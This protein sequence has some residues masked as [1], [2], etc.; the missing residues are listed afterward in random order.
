MLRRR[1]SA[2]QALGNRVVVR[3]TAGQQNGEE[4]PLSICKCV[5]LRVAPSARAA[6]SLLLLP[7]FPPAA[8]RGAPL[9]NVVNAA[10]G[11]PLCGGR[12]RSENRA[13][14]ASLDELLA[15]IKGNWRSLSRSSGRLLNWRLRASRRGKNETAYSARAGWSGALAAAGPHPSRGVPLRKG[16]IETRPVLRLQRP[17]RGFGVEDPSR[18][19]A[20]GS[21]AW[22]ALAPAGWLL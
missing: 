10:D 3:L 8:A 13:P 18:G 21:E 14:K 6:N 17:R 22:A 20:T 4:A 15:K 19:P 7:P 1:H 9:T 5:Y 16:P 2:D 11:F 12:R